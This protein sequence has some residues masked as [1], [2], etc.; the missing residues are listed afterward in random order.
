MPLRATRAIV[1]FEQQLALVKPDPDAIPLCAW[2]STS[3][4]AAG[5]KNRLNERL[6][7]KEGLTYGPMPG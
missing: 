2:P 7:Q 6:R 1:H 4:V 5:W 3:S